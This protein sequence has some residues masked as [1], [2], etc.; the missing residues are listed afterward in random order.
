[1]GAIRPLTTQ[2]E[3]ILGSLASQFR[4]MPDEGDRAT[5]AK[6]YGEAVDRLI[7]SGAWHEMP[8]P[9]DQ[10]PSEWMPPQF[11]EYWT[12]EGT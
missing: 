6:Q 1:M 11:A 10:L 9:E 8:P 4:G 5:I 12:S 2:D 7:R 3:V